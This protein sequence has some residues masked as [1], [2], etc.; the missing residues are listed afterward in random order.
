MELPRESR[1]SCFTESFQQVF[2]ESCRALVIFKDVFVSLKSITA[3]EIIVIVKKDHSICSLQT[4]V[5]Y[6]NSQHKVTKMSFK[7]DEG[8]RVETRREGYQQITVNS[9]L[10]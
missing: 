1:H 5:K 8:L 9:Q 7:Y 10:H 4:F 6:G 3:D 2:S